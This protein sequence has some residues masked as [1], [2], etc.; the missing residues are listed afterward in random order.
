MVAFRL[1]PARLAAQLLAA[2][3]AATLGFVTPTAVAEMTPDEAAGKQIFIEGRSPS[4]VPI[5]ALV[6]PHSTPVSGE[7]LPC[8]SCHGP[9]ATGRPE[10]AVRPA[11]ITWRELTKSYG[12]RTEGGRERGPYDDQ[13]FAAAVTFGTD[14]SGNKLDSTMPRYVMAN[15]DID[16]LLAYLKRIETDFDPGLSADRL[17]IGTL[18]PGTGRAAEAGQ[19]MRRVIEAHLARINAQGGIFGRQ[20]DLTVIELPGDRASA[21]QA[22]DKAMRD[23]GLFALV[24]PFAV[25]IE[26][27]LF[28]AAEASRVPVVGPFTLSPVDGPAVNRH[29]FY[30]LPGLR[31]Q[32]RALADFA[33]KQLPLKNPVAAVIH[34][35][36][37]A[38]LAAAVTEQL[39]TRGWKRVIPATYPENEFPVARIVAGLQQQGV[40]VVFFLGNEPELA[41]LGSEVR[42]AIWSPYLLALG[43]RAGAAAV[44]LPTTFGDRVY[45]AY[46][47]LPG[48]ITEQGAAAL[49]A[50]GEDT[51]ARLGHIPARVAAYGA[52]LVLEEGLKRAGRDVSRVKLAEALEKLFSFES[53][54]MPTISYGPNRRVG[55]LGA[56]IVGIDLGTHRFRP[57]GYYM[58][59]D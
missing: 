55:A 52:T 21:E 2:A 40:Q 23:T 1:R 24:A 7:T 20:L 50:A 54:V 10:G 59:L 49:V 33:A 29:T 17:R 3:I 19:A 47:T 37:D 12:H 26:Q 28:D 44:R 36:R 18:L 11:N 13:A 15:A 9:D 57:T 38:L 58:R 32:A 48:D 42:D 51:R 35:E 5:Q 4:G 45:L 43:A 22:A 30:L 6:G 27:S 46:P 8:A 14:P 31:D 56:H 53:G 34:A 41:A 16:R 39:S 25:G